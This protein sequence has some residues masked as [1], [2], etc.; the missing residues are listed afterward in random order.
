VHAFSGNKLLSYCDNYSVSKCSFEQGLCA[1]IMK[2][3]AEA[4]E[5]VCAPKNVTIKQLVLVVEQYLKDNPQDL[6]YSAVY[7]AEHA[8]SIV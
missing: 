3:V 8:L 4:S 1:G 2:G 5:K 7:L 6:H